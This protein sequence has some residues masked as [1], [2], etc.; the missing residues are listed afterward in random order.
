[1][2]KILL[3]ILFILTF[4]V[5]NITSANYDCQ[6]TL[7]IDEN[8]WNFSIC[9]GLVNLEIPA[10][11][12]TS[13]TTLETNDNFYDDS[14]WLSYDSAKFEIAWI[15][16]KF[17]NWPA[18]LK[19]ILKDSTWNK[20]NFKKWIKI[21]IKITKDLI[22][23]IWVILWWEWDSF[24]FYKDW[25]KLFAEN[26]SD[27][28]YAKYTLFNSSSFELDKNNSKIYLSNI[29]DINWILS[30]AF[31][32]NN[33]WSLE[34]FDYKSDLSNSIQYFLADIKK[35]IID[36]KSEIL[37]YEKIL[38]ITK[39]SFYD[40][41][42]KY[43]GFLTIYK[44]N[45]IWTY[46]DFKNLKKFHDDV[47][48]KF[49]VTYSN[50]KTSAEKSNT[51]D[52][53]S[54]VSKKVDEMSEKINNKLQSYKNFQNKYNRLDD[55][56]NYE[57]PN[58]KSEINNKIDKL[59]TLLSNY[60]N[61]LGYCWYSILQNYNWNSNYDILNELKYCQYS[62]E[63]LQYSSTWDSNYDYIYS[64]ILGLISNYEI[65]LNYIVSSWDWSEDNLNSKLN[66][67]S[68][69]TNL[70]QKNQSSEESNYYD[71]SKNNTIVDNSNQNTNNNIEEIDLTQIPAINTYILTNKEKL[72]VQNIWGKINKMSNT[73]KIKYKNLLNQ[74]LNKFEY[75][76]RK[77]EIA[78][79]LLDLI[80]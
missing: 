12:V 7:T 77:Y 75:G 31:F 22:D 5:I 28:F 6:K 34:N 40:E 35:M 61:D 79:W 14:I 67:L 19:F 48:S 69:Q 18:F 4:F 76:S 70:V 42:Q 23:H 44:N 72:A 20:I 56:S 57:V 36:K 41:E 27:V 54:D 43:N 37:W 33:W 30:T 29:T 62:W 45:S 50:L 38:W 59:N 17:D 52:S 39:Y 25:Y 21:N 66:Q 16:W 80:K 24:M 11:A 55:N 46:E 10:G 51:N 9:W 1:M 78:K 47:Y 60:K 58:L 26:S 49:D 65:T 63:G 74:Y 15:W 2:K 71:N 32:L 53:K 3:T 68:S 8:W 64:K 73:K 13:K